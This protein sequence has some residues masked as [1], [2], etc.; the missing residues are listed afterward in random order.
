MKRKIII[1][2]GSTATGKSSFAIDLAQKISGEIINADVGSFYKPLTIGTAKPNWKNELM[3]HHLFDILRQPVD[4]TVM[5]FRQDVQKLC[6]EIWQRGRVPIVVGGSAF[7]IRSLF[8]KQPE[9]EVSQ[10]YVQELEASLVPSQQLWNDLRS[11]DQQRAYRIDPHDRYRIIRA[12][13]IFQGTGKQPS[14]FQ[15]TF[16]PLA[17]FLFIECVAARDLLYDRI[18]K[19]VEE[20]IHAGWVNEVKKLQNTEWE[21]FLLRKKIIGY[22]DILKMVQKEQDPV[23]VVAKIQQKTRNYAKRQ[24]TFLKKLKKELLA[25]VFPA[26]IVGKVEQIDLT[27]CDVGLYISQLLSNF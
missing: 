25:E 19:R 2:T 23:E 24:I 12:L 6:S 16:D 10:L 15:Q 18:D 14:Y 27:L 17:S 13:A 4:Y 7:Y 21:P 20:M 1:I 8:Y 5:Q 3:W 22:D 9:I 11:I 26:N